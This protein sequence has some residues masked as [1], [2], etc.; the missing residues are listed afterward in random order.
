MSEQKLSKQSEELISISC[1]LSPEELIGLSRYL[2]VQ[3]DCT[4]QDGNPVELQE[5]M[6]SPK[7]FKF[8]P[9]Y[10]EFNELMEDIIVAFEMKGRSERRAL[11]RTLQKLQKRKETKEAKDG[12]Q[13][14]D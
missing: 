3:V 14:E 5:A 11:I 8:D 13:T 9:K 2:S 4:D 7:D 10:K 12:T 1:K 6:K